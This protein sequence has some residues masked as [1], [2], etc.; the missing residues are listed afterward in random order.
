[1]TTISE[2]Q[3]SSHI[4]PLNGE[5]VTTSGIVT[6]VDATGFYVQDPVGDG[7]ASTSDGV[8]VFTDSAPSVAVGD[9]VEVSGTV[10]EFIPGGPDTNN[11]SITQIVSSRVSVLSTG[12]ALPSALLV[13]ESGILPPNE[14]VIDLNELPSDGSI[15]PPLTT[16]DVSE[17]PFNP[18]EDGIDFYETLEG[19]LVTVED[20]SAISATNRFG[21]T[22]VLPNQG[23]VNVS[24][25]DGLTSRGTINSSTGEFNIGDANPERVQ[26]Q[27]DSDLLPDGFEAPDLTVAD[28]LSDVTGVV[29]YAFGNYE[30]VVTDPFSV[31]EATPLTQEVTTLTGTSPQLTV[32]SYNVLNVSPTENDADQ[33]NL[34]AEQIVENLQAPDIIGLQ[35]IQDNNG[36]NSDGSS[37]TDDGVLA[38]DETLQ[39]LIDAIAAAGGPTY[40]FIDGAPDVFMEFG[41]IP[42]GNIRNAYLYNP[43]RVTLESS[44]VLDE[45]ALAEL[46]VS[47]PNA[48]VGTRDPLLATFDFNGESITILNNHL[49]S[50]FGS[51]PIFG[52]LQPFI[53]AGEVEREAQTSALNEITDQLLADDP[54]ANIVVL[55]DLNTFEFTNDLTENLPGVGDEQVLTNLIVEQSVPADEAYTFIFQ[56]NSQVLDHVFVTDSLLDRAEFDIVHVNNDFP[57]SFNDP[58]VLVSDHEPL[59]ARFSFGNVPQTIDFDTAADSLTAGTIVTDQFAPLGVTVSAGTDE[60]M[61]FDSGNPTGG[62][63]DLSTSNLGNIL[64]ISEDGDISDPDDKASGGTIRF[65]FDELVGNLNVGLLDIDKVGS[66]I[67][68]YDGAGSVVETLEIPALGDNSI[69]EL[70]LGE[71]EAIARMDIF[72]AGSGAITELSFISAAES[73]AIG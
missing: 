3:G 48:F 23:T 72:L 66:S 29:G 59:V 8:F 11:L 14:Q 64:I 12:N 54:T 34:L 62:D 36:D 63:D 56:G 33:L 61:I 4:S 60:A 20:P 69:Q 18:T 38:A 71:G 35:E 42:G 17:T 26:I 30:V 41:G 67:T 50:R 57:A 45:E 52:S 24:P 1:M 2:I 15:Q 31:V 22:W 40:E 19:M 70:G 55:G 49:T 27:F 39:A 68:L 28:V 51:S 16:I 44:E 21:E 37:E 9:E 58:N 13:G 7:D 46:G 43:E 25:E 47:N 73:S 65:E 6:A 5:A 10:S 32:A 53:Q